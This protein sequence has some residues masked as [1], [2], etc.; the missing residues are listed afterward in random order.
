MNCRYMLGALAGGA[1]MVLAAGAVRAEGTFD[2]PAGAHFNQQKLAKIGEFFRNEVATGKIPGAVLLIEQHGKPVY[3]EF[4]G[5]RDPATKQ[6]MTDDTIFR[7]FSMTKPITSVVAMQLIDEGK[8]NLGDPVSKYIPSFA[9]VK[10]GVE[11]KSDDGK[12]TL[13]LVPPDRPPT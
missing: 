9:G 3:H 12:K 13:E 7:L 11:N 1:L 10:V 5:V 4:F 2:I 6:P 8:F